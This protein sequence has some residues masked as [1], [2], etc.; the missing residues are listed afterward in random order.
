[1]GPLVTKAWR[2]FLLPLEIRKTAAI[3][4]NNSRVQPTRG[5]SSSW[6]LDVRIITADHKMYLRTFLKGLGIGRIVLERPRIRLKSMKI[7]TFNGDNLLGWKLH[8]TVS[9]SHVM[10]GFNISDVEPS[11]YYHNIRLV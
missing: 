10:A 1:V 8:T 2:N 4:L 5:G 6:G 9:G 7:C 11:D 3:I